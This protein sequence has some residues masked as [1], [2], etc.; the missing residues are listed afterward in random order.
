MRRGWVCPISPF[1]PRPIDRQIFGSWVVFPEP[2]SPLTITTWCD[3][4]AAAISSRR[5]ETGNSSGNSMAGSGCLTGTCLEN[6]ALRVFF[7][8][9]AADMTGEL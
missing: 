2:V 5:A 7:G 3:A 9:K 8:G 4:S 1:T 6:D